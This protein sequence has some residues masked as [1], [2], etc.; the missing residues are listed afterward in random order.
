V[1][2]LILSAVGPMLPRLAVANVLVSV[3]L[4]WGCG[5]DDGGNGNGTG[6]PPTATTITQVSGDGQTG[7]AGA[8][9]AAPF[10]VRV[11][12]AQGDVVSG[13]SVSWSV[14]A[15]GGSLSACFYTDEQSGS[16]VRNPD[17]WTRGGR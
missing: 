16:G 1:R 6:P 14:T 8:A 4:V 12:D 7:V 13:L 10:V 2:S 9:L 3:L 17:T 11:T 5:G 15:G